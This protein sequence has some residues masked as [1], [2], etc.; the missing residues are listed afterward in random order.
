MQIFPVMISTSLLVEF[1]EI[2]HPIFYIWRCKL[3]CCYLATNIFLT[4]SDPRRPSGVASQACNSRLP[5]I[6]HRKKAWKKMLGQCDATA[7]CI[8]IVR[9]NSNATTVSI[10]TRWKCGSYRQRRCDKRK[11][12]KTR[13]EGAQRGELLWWV[14]W[15]STS[16]ARLHVADFCKTFV[17]FKTV[18][19]INLEDINFNT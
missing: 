13:E 3:Y 8:H 14:N 4:P 9:E 19:K 15:K 7:S 10:K 12:I 2:L 1:H 16:S 17:T 6:L 11:V 18:K 5:R